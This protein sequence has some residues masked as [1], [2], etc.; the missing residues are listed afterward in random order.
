MQ[1]SGKARGI[2]SNINFVSQ[3]GYI[4]ALFLLLRI[5]LGRTKVTNA[6]KKSSTQAGE[7]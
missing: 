5:V 1:A 4:L 7:Q 2:D 3:T 6:G